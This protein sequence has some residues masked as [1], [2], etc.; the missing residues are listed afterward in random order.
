[1]TA[2]KRN[3]EKRR[4]ESGQ[5]FSYLMAC[6]TVVFSPSVDGDCWND[7]ERADC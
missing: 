5:D 6:S 7:D 2:D 1:M 3:V 4:N